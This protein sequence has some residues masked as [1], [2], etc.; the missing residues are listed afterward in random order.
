MTSEGTQVSESD[1]FL[2]TIINHH[3]FMTIYDRH[4]LTIYDDHKSSIISVFHKQAAVC[5][6]G[7]SLLK[8]HKKMLIVVPLPGLLWRSCFCLKAFKKKSRRNLLKTRDGQQKE[9]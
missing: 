1:S 9:R 6:Q 7:G 4:K 8:Q 5:T 3:K 2:M